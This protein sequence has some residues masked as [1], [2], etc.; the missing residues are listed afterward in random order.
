LK[1]ITLIIMEAGT[2]GRK[3]KLED[4]QPKQVRSRCG[5]AAQTLV[6]AAMHVV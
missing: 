3:R 2:A 6:V 4:W 5:G 1:S